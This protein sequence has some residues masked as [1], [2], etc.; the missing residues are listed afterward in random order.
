MV[1]FDN[2][3]PFSAPTTPSSSRRPSRPVA[4]HVQGSAE[5]SSSF[6][7]PESLQP[8]TVLAAIEPRDMT[9]RPPLSKRKS[10]AAVFRGLEHVFDTQAEDHP[11][12][13][14]T[15]KIQPKGRSAS[16]VLCS[17]IMPLTTSGEPVRPSVRRLRSWCPMWS[18]RRQRHSMRRVPSLD[19]EPRAF[20]VSSR[21][22]NSDH[23][24]R[25]YVAASRRE[26]L[27]PMA[28][29]SIVSG[30]RMVISTTRTLRTMMARE[31]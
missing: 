15:P 12:D 13:Y 25:L 31:S 20:R 14:R 29:F 19:L 1:H 27:T 11:E 7:P 10:S 8:D 16:L 4:P 28:T 17:P 3:E 21:A 6:E 9:T 18:N 2:P 26:S 23:S 22:R 24:Y 30:L 5:A